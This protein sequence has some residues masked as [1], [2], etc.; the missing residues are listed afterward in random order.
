MEEAVK[1]ER[2][3]MS[4]ASPLLQTTKTAEDI[5]TSTVA[6]VEAIPIL[7]SSLLDRIELFTR[8]MDKVAEVLFT[9]H[10]LFSF[11]N[12]DTQGSPVLP[13]GVGCSVRCPKGESNA[14]FPILFLRFLIYRLSSSRRTA[15]TVLVTLSRP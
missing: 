13:N 5:V 7:W 1:E 12:C 10:G 14:D 4:S 11:T 15:I 9:S 6:G 8:M 3:T 2:A